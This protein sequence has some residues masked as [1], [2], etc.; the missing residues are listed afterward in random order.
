[1]GPDE[2]VV[3]TAASIGLR[4]DLPDSESGE[5]LVSAAGYYQRPERA[6]TAHRRRNVQAAQDLAARL[7]AGMTAAGMF[8]QTWRETVARLGDQDPDRRVQIRAVGAMR[9]AEWMVTRVISV[10]AH[11]L[12]IALTLGRVPWTTSAALTVMRAVFV[13]LLGAEPPPRLA[14]D[15]QTLLEVGTGRRALTSTER[16]VLGSLQERFPLLS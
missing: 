12:D 4:G 10:A 1:M 7:P 14:W 5:P 2:L 16:M 11:G 6:T 8:E 9:L 15:N 13:S 3:H